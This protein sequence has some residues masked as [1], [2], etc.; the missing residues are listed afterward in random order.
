MR[1]LENL[2]QDILDG[3]ID[4]FYVF[5]GTDFGIRKHYIEQIKKS[6]NGK[7]KY[8]ED[9]TKIQAN[10][11]ST[12]LFN[13]NKQLYIVYNDI[14]FAESK[15]S[16]IDKFIK[17]LTKD[18]VILVYEEALSSSNLFKNFDK[19]ITEFPEVQANI[20]KE[21]VKSEV[22]LLDVD[23]E[24][25]SYNCKNNYNMI[26]LE[27]DK[28]K[29][30]ASGAGTSIS[31]S[32]ETLSVKNQLTERLDKF[33]VNAFMVDVLC[34]NKRNMRY[35]Y[36][37]AINDV[38]SFFGSL[39]YMFNDYLIS[40]ILKHYGRSD[41]SSIAYDSGFAW[42]RVKVLRELI[43][44][45][46]PDDLIFMAYKIACVDADVKTGKLDRGNVVDYFFSSIIEI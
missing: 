2:K 14:E 5:Y 46:E 32:F 21:F 36:Q 8:L 6:F 3:K 19:Y 16:N 40:Y 13:S 41:G 30:Y 11:K 38:N 4:N 24:A 37:I 42:G 25:L 7:G 10:S 31:N 23:A 44:P 39:I 33:D 45:L 1:K 34:N 29:S 35:W 43:I 27:T 22:N 28:I 9:C 17:N 18:T 15:S 20:G 12:S 26:L